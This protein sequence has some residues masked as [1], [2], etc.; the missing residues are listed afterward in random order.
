MRVYKGCLRVLSAIA[1]A[2]CLCGLCLCA[3]YK[4]DLEVASYRFVREVDS[5]LRILQLSDLHNHS[6]EYSS[7]S[8]VE[9]IG[10]ANPDIVVATG[11]LID[12]HTKTFDNL[13]AILRKIKSLG[14]PL[15]YVHG[16]HEAG[17]SEQMFAQ[18]SSLLNKYGGISCERK[19]IDIGNGYTITGL[20]DPTFLDADGKKDRAMLMDAQLSD[21]ETTSKKGKYNIVLVHQPQFNQQIYSHGYDIAFSGHT[22]GGQINIKGLILFTNTD[23]VSGVYYRGDFAQVVSNGLGHSFYLPFR[24]ACPAQLVVADLAK[25]S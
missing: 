4:D 3:T 23:Y 14:V 9:Q 8:I 25:A 15:Y 18:L 2:G 12:S 10:K 20:V 22:H 1:A 21:I 19:S 5:D 13:E 16:N 11:D 24:H 7:T 6:N 17:V